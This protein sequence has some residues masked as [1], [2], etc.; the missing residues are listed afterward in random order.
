MKASILTIGDELLLGHVLDTNAHYLSN[1]LKNA[2]FD[3]VL[4]LTLKDTYNELM[5]GIV[6]AESQSDLILMTGGL[7]P[8]NDDITKQVLADYFSCSLVEN[9]DALKMISDLL[10]RKGVKLTANNREQAMIPE[11]AKVLPNTI[12]TASGMWFSTS[13]IDLISMP[14]VPFEMKALMS[15]QVLPILSKRN[16]M[17]V[18]TK[19]V[20]TQ[21]LPE[22]ILAEKIESW[23]RQLSTGISLAYLPTPGYIKLRLTAKGDKQQQLKNI[24]N[25]EVAKLYSYIPEYILG[26]DEVTLEALLHKILIDRNNTLCTAESCTGGTIASKLLHIPGSSAFFEGAFVTYSNASKETLLGVNAREIRRFGAVSQEVVEQMARGARERL[27]TDYAIA[28]SGVAGPSG[29]TEEKPVGT[30]WIAWAGKNKVISKRFLFSD[31]RDV[32]IARSTNVAV[33]Q[34]IKLIKAGEI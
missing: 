24:V 34:L 28:T 1:A 11:A 12:G 8:T 32:N 16:S 19:F 17:S 15:G 10:Q 7:G 9:A 14:G 13:K 2:G 5:S 20:L 3:V 4:R 23:E 33:G 25:R 21:G 26:E 18:V 30:V 6:Y 29:G 31:E 22:S 27:S